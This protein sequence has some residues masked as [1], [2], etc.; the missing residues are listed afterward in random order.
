MPGALEA[1]TKRLLLIAVI[2]GVAV[3]M[4]GSPGHGARLVQHSER[5]GRIVVAAICGLVLRIWRRGEF[6]QHELHSR[7]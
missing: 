7:S 1:I 5:G 3:V 6:K 2:L 4:L